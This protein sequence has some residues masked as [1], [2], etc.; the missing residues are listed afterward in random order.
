MASID[1]LVVAY[2]DQAMGPESAIQ[3]HD[4]ATA[5]VL[6]F[7]AKVLND[8]ADAM[9]AEWQAYVEANYRPGEALVFGL[10]SDWLR[11]RARRA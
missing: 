7:R 6:A 11:A 10:D 9:D 3:A 5:A 8:A 2:A 4:D 1:D